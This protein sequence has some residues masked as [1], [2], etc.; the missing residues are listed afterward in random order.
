MIIISR[1]IIFLFLLTN[2]ANANVTPR[3]SDI[4][5]QI[6]GSDS[7][8]DPTY[9]WD[10]NSSGWG[11][12]DVKHSVLPDGSATLAEQQSQTSELID[13]NGHLITL[14]TY[15]DQVESKLDTSNGYLNSIDTDFDVSLSTRASESTLLSTNIKLDTVNSNLVTI[16]GKQDTGNASLASIDSDIDT[17]LSTRASESTLSSFQSANHTDLLGIQTRVDSTNTKIDTVNT[18]L[19]TIQGKQDSQTTQLTAINANTDMLETK[20]GDVAETAPTTDTATSGL[21][22]RLQ[23]IAQRLT[24]L[25][26]FYFSD[27]GSSANSIRTAAQIG[28]ATGAANFNSG[29]TGAQT[30]RVAANLYD[31]SANALTSRSFDSTRPLDVY[32]SQFRADTAT[33]TTV[34]P[35]AN[36]STQL[37]ASNSARKWVLFIN[38]SGAP[39]FLSLG[40]TATVNNGIEVV[41]NGGRFI[42]E[43]TFL[44]TGTINGIV[45][46]N[47]RTIEI[48]EAH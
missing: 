39:F 18:N 5:V 6:Y 40:T 20:I 25:I 45:A 31:G 47:S 4:H 36:T 17:A 29:A 15:L 27:F 16:Q 28:N 48:Y 21:N 32:I 43:A 12:V 35:T 26:G 41:S 44:Y 10:I 11:S 23:R 3:F 22:G 14:E 33:R 8:G 42:M 38:N 1:A 30:L 34:T 9:P 13:I 46:S 24:T 19:V 7:N 37:L 2:F